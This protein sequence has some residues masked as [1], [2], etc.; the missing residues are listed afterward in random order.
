M[1]VDVPE[2]VRQRAL[3]NGA[4]GRAWLDDLPDVV[5]A[6]A[7]RWGLELGTA[8]IGGTAGYVVEAMGAGGCR[9]S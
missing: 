5:A 1:D 8:F 7:D 4:A 6:L 3:A 9:A 2:L